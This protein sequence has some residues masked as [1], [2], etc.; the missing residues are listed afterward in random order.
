[1]TDAVPEVEPI[2][3][4]TGGTAGGKAYAAR[5]DNDDF[6]DWTGQDG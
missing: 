6:Y 4:R 3:P 1:M 2:P 5:R